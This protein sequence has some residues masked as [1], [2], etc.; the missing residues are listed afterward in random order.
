MAN[1]DKAAA[2]GLEVFA[3]TQ[4]ARLGY[5]NDNIRGD[6]LADHMTSGTHT[7]AQIIGLADTLATKLTKTQDQYAADFAFRDSNIGTAQTTANNAAALAASKRAQTDG[8]FGA[9]PI[10]TPHGRANGVTT[11]YVAAYLN[12]DGRIG[13]SPSSIRYK[14]NVVPLSVEVAD[15]LA[16]EPVEFDRINGGHEVGMI[17]EQVNEHVPQVVVWTGDEI[18]GVHY[19]LLP[20]LLLKVVQHQAAQIDALAAEVARLASLIEPATTPKED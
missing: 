11:S 8:D 10:Y 12:G 4:D 19:H 18:D 2:A 16:L 3:A 14:E 13:A 1:G 20:V 9:V 6:E 15:I 5:D 7:Q 17:A